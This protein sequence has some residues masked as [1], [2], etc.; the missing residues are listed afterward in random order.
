MHPSTA[1]AKPSSSDMPHAIRCEPSAPARS[2]TMPNDIRPRPVLTQESS[3][4]SLAR[5]SRT[6]VARSLLQSVSFS[7]MASE[8]H[9][10]RSDVASLQPH[11]DESAHVD[12]GDLDGVVSVTEPVPGRDV[13]LH[14]AGR[15]GCSGSKGVS[16]DVGH[17]PVERPILPLVRTLRGLEL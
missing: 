9:P 1:N 12:V 10:A 13:G 17:L 6:S 8:P 11:R 7:A 14:V 5:C 4:R 16:A 2:T 3:V 15:V